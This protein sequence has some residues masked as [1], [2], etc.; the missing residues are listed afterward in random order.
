MNQ[1]RPLLSMDFYV[2]YFLS[3]KVLLCRCG[4][5]L[6]SWAQFAVFSWHFEQSNTD[7][8][9][10]DRCLIHPIDVFLVGTK[11]RSD[12]TTKFVPVAASS[13]L[14]LLKPGDANMWWISETRVDGQRCKSQYRKRLQKIIWSGWKCNPAYMSQMVLS[15]DAYKSWPGSQTLI[16]GLHVGLVS[17]LV[18]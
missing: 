11:K 12:E 1:F 18:Y 15:P 5:R 16:R 8:M 7:M 13:C 6:E 9:P 4:Y 14:T 2:I 10:C 3:N 17:T